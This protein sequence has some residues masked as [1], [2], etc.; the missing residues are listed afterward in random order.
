MTMNVALFDCRH[1]IEEIA[2]DY[3]RTGKL[4]YG[5]RVRVRCSSMSPPAETGRDRIAR[6][7]LQFGLIPKR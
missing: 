4:T 2:F 6:S 3:Q 5:W 1:C 7:M